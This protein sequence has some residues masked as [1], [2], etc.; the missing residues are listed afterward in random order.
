MG[1]RAVGKA[2]D[3]YDEDDALIMVLNEK[4]GTRA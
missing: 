2:N 3:Y 4:K 1:M